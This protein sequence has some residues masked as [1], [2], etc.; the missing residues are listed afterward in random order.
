[1]NAEI[2]AVGTELLLGQ[3]LNTNA[4]FLSQKLSQLGVNVF[5]QTTVGDNENRLK[6]ALEAALYRADV[7]ILTGGLG[8][9]KDDLTKETVAEVMQIPLIIDDESAQRIKNYFFSMG[10]EMPQ[11]NLKQA[12]MPGGCKILS[13]DKGTAPGCIIE[14]NGKIVILLPGPPNEMEPMFNNHVF[15]Y[16]RSKNNNVIHSKVLRVFGIGESALEENISHIIDLQSN[17]TIAPYA[18]QGEVVL[19]ITAKSEDVGISMG[20]IRPIEDKIREIF[21]DMVYGEGDDNSLEQTVSE[22]LIDSGITIAT[23]ESCTGGMLAERLTRMPSISKCFGR[24]VITY[25]NEA[26]I[27]LLGVSTNTLDKYGAVSMQTAMEMA[28]GIRKISGADLGVS[29]TGIAGPDGGT[30]VKPVGLVYLGMSTAQ[31]TWSKELRLTGSRERIRNMSVM[32]ALD[33]IRL[34]VLRVKN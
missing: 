21:G 23:A 26:K 29:I 6:E 11:S 27:K 28:D 19:R 15:S 22:Y 2:I 31:E 3:I 12:Y 17:P 34:Y 7:V 5:F 4:Q 25:S 24:G 8:P 33:M 16:I 18:K 20:L 30:E 13:N 14:M 10:R 32:Y 9:T 1:M